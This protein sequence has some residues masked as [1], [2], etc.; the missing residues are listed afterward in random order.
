MTYQSSM[1]VPKLSRINKFIIITCAA[2][3]F[4][5]L[6]ISKNS[7]FN[8]AQFL[9]LNPP[10]LLQG[11]IHQLL[12]Y[13]LINDG[14]LGVIFECMIVWFIG[15][16]LE[17]RWGEKTYILFLLSAVVGAAILYSGYGLIFLGTSPIFSVRMMGLSGLCYA[18][19]IAYGLIFS[20]RVLSFMM[21]FP[22]QA[23]YFVWLIV[24]IE[25]VMTF[26]ASTRTTA[27]G[28]LS[29]MGCGYLFLRYRSYSSQGK[30]KFVE[31]ERHKRLEKAKGRLY[32]VPEEDSK[33]KD[34]PKYWH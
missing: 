20:D 9:A 6:M 33:K 15:S 5:N 22:V 13:P 26:S 17:A 32:V 21:I 28:H 25:L 34:D 3:Y 29:A 14:F 7:N 18:L 30:A 27:L 12:T 19:L 16:D 31:V 4:L 2:I 8:L 1:Y 24:G 10:M 11:H 23:R